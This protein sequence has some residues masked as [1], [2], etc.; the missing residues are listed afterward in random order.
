MSK[1]DN[2]NRLEK[3]CSY[4][5]NCDLI[6]K[7]GWSPVDCK[8]WCEKYTWDEKTI[9]TK[10]EF[11]SKNQ[12]R[13]IVKAVGEGDKE[14][15]MGLCRGYADGVLEIAVEQPE[16]VFPLDLKRALIFLGEL[17]EKE[18]TT[19]LDWLNLLADLRAG[20]RTFVRLLEKIVQIEK[21]NP[22]ESSIIMV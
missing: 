16:V 10:P 22:K 3:S 11:F 13:R 21:N 5:N 2:E 12:L 1:D 17:T 14:V 19:Y 8:G 6:E 9:P 7:P 15:L 18:D 20:V 4:V